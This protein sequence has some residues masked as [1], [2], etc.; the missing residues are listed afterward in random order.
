MNA[1]LLDGIFFDIVRQLKLLFRQIHFIHHNHQI[2]SYLGPRAKTAQS[3]ADYSH[4]QLFQVISSQIQPLFH[5][6]AFQC[7]STSEYISISTCQHL[8][9][10]AFQYFSISAFHNFL[11]FPVTPAISSNFSPLQQFSAKSITY[12]HF[13]PCIAISRNI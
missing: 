4:F 5:I 6:S 12:S 10:S 3:M 1:K 8:S 11:L 7:F 9:I 13:Q 2:Q